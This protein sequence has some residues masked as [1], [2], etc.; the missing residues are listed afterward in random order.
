MIRFLI[1][2][3]LCSICC[4]TFGKEKFPYSFKLNKSWFLQSSEKVPAP[5]DLISCPE[6]KTN[7]WYETAVPAT[8]LGA[9]VKNNV[10]KDIFSGN[11]LN[12][13]PKDQFKKSWWYRKEF[14]IPK[15]KGLNNAKLCFDGI[16]YSADIWFNG[17]K[18][19]GHDSI[20]GVFRQFEIDISQYADFGKPNVLAVE[21]FPPVPGDLTIGFVD[22]NPVPPDKNMG[23][24]REVY[25]KLTGEVSINHP[26]VVS[27]L[28]LKDFKKA[29]LT[30][31]AEIENNSSREI[32]GILEG[33]IES[34]KFS[35]QVKLDPRQTRLISFNSKD[36]NRLNIINPRVW[37]THDLG[38]QETYKLNL[39]FHVNNEVSDESES[40]FGIREVS[41]Y[42]NEQ[43][44]RGYKLNG[45]KILIRGGGWVDDLLLNNTYE[46]IETQI[47]YAVQSNLNTI[48]LEG[49]WG[50]SH[51]LYNLCDKYG[52]LIMAGW[53][54]QWEWEEYVGKK[55]DDYGAVNS[56]EDFKLITQSWKDQIKWLRR[57]PSIFL[58]LYG[59]DKHPKPDLEAEYLKIL[60]EC[61]STRPCL[62]SATGKASTLTGKTGVKM[63][64]PYDYVP[65]VYWYL[66]TLQGGAFGFN[67]ETGPGVQIPV[68]EDIKK[69]IPANH[70]WPIDSIWNYHC[71]GGEFS[72]L[73][74]YTEVMNNRLGAAES[75][76]DFSAK[77]QFL[78]YEGMRA[79]FEAFQLRK[80]NTTGIIQ[81]MFN[82]AWPKL[83]WQLFDY[84][85]V[86]TAAMY[87]ARKANEPMHILYNYGNH[88]VYA[89]N[90]SR[91]KEEFKSEVRVLNFDLS[92]KY[93]RKEIFEL[94][95]DGVYKAADLGNI[96]GLSAAYY[97]DLKLYDK[98][99]NLVSNNF[100]CLSSKED[101]PDFSKS[102]WFVTPES[103]YADMKLLNKLPVVNL[104]VTKKFNKSGDR[105]LITVELKNPSKEL[106]LQV[107]LIL[108]NAEDGSLIVPVYW[109]D[110]YFS[111]LPGEKRIV[112]GY[113]TGNEKN[114]EK[115]VL[116]AR[117]WNIKS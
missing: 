90:N 100:Y 6:F 12:Q 4:F 17:K 29:A 3:L 56:A 115:P 19:A 88:S 112:R 33:E 99:N 27:K 75:L 94:E 68:L 105:Q 101:V 54:C 69:F 66:D 91:H 117:G 23:I 24:W 79:M 98:K 7:G 49:F 108:K 58:W 85:L 84:Y 53:S 40:I 10:Y 11:N 52:I 36:H 77:S 103:Q 59:S 60:S 43:G 114:I 47:K 35:Q 116:K 83:W 92:E 73:N 18:I 13:I 87:G 34:I 1:S 93:S 21:I 107:E 2:F 63:N 55:V 97:V 28:D 57:H 61:D 51:D 72:N 113:F 95:P 16:N 50:S 74:R 48:R 32:S 9:L 30:I 62:S 46:N 42:F 14:I 82:A 37:W 106:A 78:N 109:D 64:G 76:E 26:Y 102:L 22:W 20:E 41:D 104:D 31:S 25:V 15:L 86:P 67:T 71:G 39:S 81:W 96:A 44:H 8:V 70:L 111:L 65:P 45:K 89:V 80:F 5:G 38:S 110:N